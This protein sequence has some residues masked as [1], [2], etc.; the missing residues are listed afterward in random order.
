VVRK[1][2][3]TSF[4]ILFC[5]A[6]AA[7]QQPGDVYGQIQLPNGDTPREPIRFLLTSDDGRV[8]ENHFTDSSGRFILKGL[9]LRASYT[10]TVESDGSTYDRTAYTFTPDYNATPRVILRPLARA[11]A[12]AGGTVSL[13]ALRAKP[14]AREAHEAAMKEIE[15]KRLGEAEKHLRRAI[16]ADPAFV[17]P[18][19]D[20]GALLMG[21]KRYADAEAILR[22]GYAADPKS[23]HLLLNL[24]I[25]LNHQQKFTEAAQILREALK[26]QPGL[27]AAHLH[28]GAALVELDQFDP[29]ED[30]LQ[31]VAKSE[32]K[33]GIAAQLYLGKLYARTGEFPKGIAALELYLQKAPDA[34]NAREVRGL[35]EQM[36]RAMAQ[37]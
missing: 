19:S 12:P 28:L 27:V 30:H 14:E 31:R 13:G 1:I 11:A 9:S 35:I 10:I 33:E 32:D 24:G 5:A 34:A 21:Q 37:K 8:N 18:F 3:Q 20:L 6:V 23:V 15:R 4:L 25:S 2:L 22:Q 26:V 36:K 17:D 16:K 29:A 7:A